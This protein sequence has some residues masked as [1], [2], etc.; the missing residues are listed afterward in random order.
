[1]SSIPCSRERVDLGHGVDPDLPRRTAITRRSKG[2]SRHRSPGSGRQS[3]LRTDPSPARLVSSWPRTSPFSSHAAE[4]RTSAARSGPADAAGLGVERDRA[5]G[6]L[7]QGGELHRSLGGIAGKA[8]PA[9]TTFW[10][11]T[12][13]VNSRSYECA[14]TRAIPRASSRSL[15]SVSSVWSGQKSRRVNASASPRWMSV[16]LGAARLS[17]SHFGGSLRGSIVRTR[18]HASHVMRGGPGSRPGIPGPIPQR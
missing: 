9:A 4:P 1:M 6:H 12:P 2:S 11:W 7:V 10:K 17:S 8:S 18:P 3:A 14:S 16:H 5:R 15:S 13:G